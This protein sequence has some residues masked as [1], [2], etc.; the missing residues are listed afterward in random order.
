MAKKSKSGKI[1]NR[2]KEIRS[3]TQRVCRRAHDK[4]VSGIFKDDTTNKKMW[5]YIKSKKQEHV[6]IPDIKD[7]NNTMT[8][9][10]QKKAQIIHE[11]FDSVYSDPTSKITP[12]FEESERLPTMPNIEINYNGILKL[13]QNIN[14]NKAVGPDQIPGKF[15]KL[16]CDEMAFIF[17]TLFQAS[18]N[19]GIIPSDQL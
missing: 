16:C 10:P 5:S 19:Q 14:P 1:W 13:L 18:V 6:S 7:K 4:Y 15:L 11:Q 12:N 9:D 2:Y 3:E 8:S 17:Q